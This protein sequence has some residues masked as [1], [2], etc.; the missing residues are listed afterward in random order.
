[1]TVISIDRFVDYIICPQ[2]HQFKEVDNQ[3][4]D[5]FYEV[6]STIYNQLFDYCFYLK[7]SD[8]AITLYK[9]NLKLN[10]LWDEIKNNIKDN[11][12]IV[13]KLV[14]KNKLSSIEEMFKGISNVIYY[15][16]PCFIPIESNN[17]MYNIFTYEDNY[18]LK[19]IVKFKN[20]HLGLKKDSAT[21]AIVYSLLYYNFKSIKPK[22]ASNFYLYRVDTSELYKPDLIPQK[23][24]RPIV[25]NITEGIEKKIVYPRNDY[26][27]CFTCKHKNECSWSMYK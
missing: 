8:E 23:E 27:T 9:L 20:Y 5:N 6:R 18:E 22:Y 25:K 12:G 15:N 11:I 24:L 4:L 3:F 13:N 16:V 19:T 17:I 21:V 14:I 7:T 26:L 2:R 1:M 10:V